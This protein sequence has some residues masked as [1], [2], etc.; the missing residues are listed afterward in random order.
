MA[1]Q[2]SS[3][4][5]FKGINSDNLE[6]ASV[7][8]AQWGY[9]VSDAVNIFFAQIAEERNFPYAEIPN[10][11]TLAAIEKSSNGEGLYTAKNADDLFRHLGLEDV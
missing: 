10:E 6:K 5:Y 7:I 2:A 8:L 4:D 1:K 9:S 3:T 11:T